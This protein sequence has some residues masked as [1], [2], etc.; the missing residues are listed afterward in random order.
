MKEIKINVDLKDLN[1]RFYVFSVEDYENS[2]G[3]RDLIFLCD[4]KEE[5]KYF[6]DAYGGERGIDILDKLEARYF[7]YEG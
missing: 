5:Y 3:L 1:K 6:I 4:T 7:E 2:G